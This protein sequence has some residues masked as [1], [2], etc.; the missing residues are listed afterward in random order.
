MD[1][2]LNGIN[3]NRVVGTCNK[4]LVRTAAC[5][6]FLCILSGVKMMAASPGFN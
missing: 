4:R 5:K 1:T 3:G 6:E 2:A